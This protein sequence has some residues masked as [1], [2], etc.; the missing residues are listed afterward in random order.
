V[1]S[2]E[3]T[4]VP[5]IIYGRKLLVG[6]LLSWVLVLGAGQAAAQDAAGL[7]A[8]TEEAGQAET[9]DD[10]AEAA[11]AAQLR[12]GATVYAQVCASCHQAGG[13]GLEGQFPPL[14][15]NANID[16]TTYVE[17]VISN[18]RTGEIDVDGVV[19]D[20][21]MPSFSTLSDD[22]TDA[23]IAFMQ[24]DFVAPPLS[25]LQAPGPV[26]ATESPGL[27]NLTYLV[28]FG[29]FAGVT[30]LVLGPRI[31]SENDRL[32]VSWLDACLKTAVI[33]SGVI[34]LTVVIP[35]WAIRR[36][37]VTKLSRFSQDLVGVLLWGF[38]IVVVTGSLWYAHRRSRV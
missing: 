13:A 3:T 4:T 2:P 6:A 15:D 22:D 20:G 19:Y 24:N 25:A 16:D 21:V 5:R 37:E 14:M 34:L 18:G 30:L 38:G 12:E 27:S 1:P 8:A 36:D 23:V 31:A 10:A 33:V 9:T 7:S 35:D 29:L 32:K 17:T 11:A 26:G 28:G